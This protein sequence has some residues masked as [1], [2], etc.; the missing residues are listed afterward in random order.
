[1]AASSVPQQIE[2]LLDE[3]PGRMVP[4]IVQAEEN[5][6][7]AKATASAA[8]ASLAERR[9]VVR[10]ADVVGVLARRRAGRSRRPNRP[11]SGT[12]AVTGTPAEQSRAAATAALRPVLATDAVRRALARAGENPARSTVTP[13]LAARSV[14]ATLTRDELAALRDAPGAVAAVHHNRHLDVPRV[15]EL[16]ELPA[17]AAAVRAARGASTASARW[18]PGAATACGARA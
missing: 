5:D 16:D 13:L 11:P 9:L 17:A 14:A 7:V 6:R 1:M 4:V 15:I 12:A 2:R 3:N 18:P 10:P 8:A